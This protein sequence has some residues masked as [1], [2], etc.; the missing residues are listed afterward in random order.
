MDKLQKTGE[1]LKGFCSR[2]S[3]FIERAAVLLLCVG[4]CIFHYHVREYRADTLAF[5]ENVKQYSLLGFLSWRVNTWS[6]RVILEGLLY[7]ILTL[8]YPVFA[9]INSLIILGTLYALR[10]LLEW[11]WLETT[12]LSLLLFLFPMDGLIEVGIQPGAINYIW[13]LAAAVT[14]LL[15]LQMIYRGKQIRW[16][17]NI[18]F[19][20][21][22]VIG[23][24]ME[25]TA[26]IVFCFYL[27]AVVYFVKTKKLQPI[28]FSQMLLSVLSLIFIMTCKGNAARV[29][30]ET[31]TYWNEFEKLSVV[32]KLWNGWFTTVEYFYS[33]REVPFL[34]FI[35]ALCVWLW[36]KYKKV[37]LFTICGTLPLLGRAV[38]WAGRFPD[39]MLGTRIREWAAGV[40]YENGVLQAPPI[41]VY[42]Q[43]ILYTVFFLMIGVA[44]YGSFRSLEEKALVL[45]IL[46]AGFATRLIMGFSPTLIASG[47]RT[48]FFMDA[49]LCIGTV[50]IARKIWDSQGTRTS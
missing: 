5:Q 34:I 10:K 6:G 35:A 47:T 28:L 37:N 39:A 4:L 20:A 49:A 15:P 29:I 3:I 24:N 44:V 50:W 48:F 38:I 13:A 27:L 33:T 12:V 16:Y 25:Q 22:A 32:Q 40:R 21:A 30:Q 45:L 31:A 19:G 8:P 1:K 17:H 36:I 43:V 26:A 23:C 41:P 9:F 42:P 11:G 18:G 14:A 7:L 46:T 2:N